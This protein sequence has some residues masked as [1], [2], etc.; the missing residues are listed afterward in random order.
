MKTV[1]MKKKKKMIFFISFIIAFI[2]LITIA[3]NSYSATKEY[4]LGDTNL[5]NQITLSDELLL[6][7]HIYSLKS[8]K[9]ENWRLSGDAVVNADI[10]EDKKIDMSDVLYMKRYLLAQKDTGIAEKHTEWTKLCKKIT[11]ESTDIIKTYTLAI[12]PGDQT[13]TRETKTTMTITA[14]EVSYTVSFNGNE[15]TSPDKEKSIRNFSNWTLSGAGKVEDK[16]A[17]PTTYT[18]GEGDATLTANYNKEGNSIILPNAKREEYVVEGWYDSKELKNKVGNVGD[19]YTP[20]QDITLYANWTK[21]KVEP[22]SVELNKKDVLID[23]SDN[24]TEK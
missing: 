13:Y 18:F 7:R 1:K 22:T 23:I 14:P 20:T 9:N 4:Y 2:M 3:Y 19:S 10:N 24:K 11:K 5:D 17:S 16:K 12:K 21:Q 6:L 15:G 8:D